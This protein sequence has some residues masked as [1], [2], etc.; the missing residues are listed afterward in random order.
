MYPTCVLNCIPDLL[1]VH[2]ADLDVGVPLD[3]LPRPLGRPLQ[4]R[5][6]GVVTRPRGA[7]WGA[8]Q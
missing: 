4:G 7:A 3:E 1:A 6:P 8:I 2:R 5:G